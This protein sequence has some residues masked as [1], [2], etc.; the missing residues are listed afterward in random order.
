MQQPSHHS[1]YILYE[2]SS[3]GQIKTTI[4]SYGQFGRDNTKKLFYALQSIIWLKST[5]FPVSFLIQSTTRLMLNC[6]HL[7]CFYCRSHFLL[8][9]QQRR[10]R[11]PWQVHRRQRRSLKQAFQ[12]PHRVPVDDL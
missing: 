9:H 4:I 3:D 11:L 10:C 7:F 5:F 6:H 8:I 2:K 1:D 12:R